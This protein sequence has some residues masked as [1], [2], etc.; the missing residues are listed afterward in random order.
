M[1]IDCGYLGS[2]RAS[3]GVSGRLFPPDMFRVFAGGAFN[4]AFVPIFSKKL[5]KRW[6]TRKFRRTHFAGM[7]FILTCSPIIGSSRCRGLVVV[8]GLV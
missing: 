6:T 2:A 7:A 3:R 8:D 1:V 5:R 4:M